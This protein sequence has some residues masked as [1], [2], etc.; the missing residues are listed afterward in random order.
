MSH[1]RERDAD[2]VRV[3]CFATRDFP[4]GVKALAERRAARFTG[5]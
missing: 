3:L 4:E 1:P 5:A 2:D